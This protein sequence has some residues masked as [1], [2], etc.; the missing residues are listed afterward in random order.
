MSKDVL[1]SVTFS[2]RQM[3]QGAIWNKLF[4]WKFKLKQWHKIIQCVTT[5]CQ[6]CVW[7]SWLVLAQFFE[8]SLTIIVNIYIIILFITGALSS[9]DPSV[10]DQEASLAAQKARSTVSTSGMKKCLVGKIM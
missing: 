1:V 9:T 4:N 8:N 2:R 3:Q 5:G 7:S 6:L 10:F